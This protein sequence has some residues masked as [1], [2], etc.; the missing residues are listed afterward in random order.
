MVDEAS[1]PVLGKDPTMVDDASP[2]VLGT[3]PTTV[4]DGSTASAALVSASDSAVMRNTV[5]GRPCARWMPWSAR[6]SAAAVWGRWSGSVSRQ[7]TIRSAR[8]SGTSSRRGRSPWMARISRAATGSP[9][10]VANGECPAIRACSVAPSEYT[11]LRS[12]GD[13][14]C[15][16]SV[17]TNPGVNCAAVAEV[18]SET[19]AMPKSAS[20]TS[21]KG[22]TSRF[23]G[24]TSRWMR[25]A[26]C[27]APR[28]PAT[29][30]PMS[31]TSLHAS[32]P[33]LRIRSAIEPRDMYSMASQGW[34][35][36]FTPESNT[37]TTFGCQERSPMAWHSRSK[38]RTVASS[39]SFARSTLSATCR[40][41]RTC[42]AR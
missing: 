15:R 27:T 28:A 39:R 38:R 18:A 19:T 3:A 20:L 23:S 14:P 22:P 17:E 9:F 40:S 13:F 6:P 2:P 29:C 34:P 41:R 26:A 42:R 16:T 25:P 36:A 8:S 1:S 10:T 21:P 11:S 33:L 24:L 4:A 35:S 32:G 7:E 31:T 12:S 5:T 37:P 30:T